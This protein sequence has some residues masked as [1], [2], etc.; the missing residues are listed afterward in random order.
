MIDARRKT[1]ELGRPVALRILLTKRC[2]SWP[3]MMP[4]AM[5]QAASSAPRMPAVTPAR[6]AVL[7]NFFSVTLSHCM[8]AGRY[9]YPAATLR[10]CRLPRITAVHH[11]KPPRIGIGVTYHSQYTHCWQLGSCWITLLMI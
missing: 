2:P 3:E 7:G 10:A 5:H 11:A 9:G 8:S 4:K 6:R 1:T